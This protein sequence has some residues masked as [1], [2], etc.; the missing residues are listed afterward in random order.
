MHDAPHP[1]RLLII[2]NDR[3]GDLLL[4]LPAL[5]YARQVWP[6][7]QIS[8]LVSTRTASL[9]RGN[10]HVDQVLLDDGKASA[11]ALAAQLR[12]HA[13][14]AAIAVF[15][16]T[17]NCLAIWQARI[18]LRVTWAHK[19]VGCLLGNRRV[20]VR[21]SHPPVHES[22]FALAFVRRLKNV[23]GVTL[24]PPSI[25]VDPDARRR[26][27]LRIQND[28]GDQGP[29]FGIHPGSY[30]S[31]YNWPASRYVELASRL[32]AHGRV[33]VTGGPGEREMLA[34]M[35]SQLPAAI[36][37]RVA[38]YHEFDLQE[39]AAAISRYDVLTVSNTGP[40]HLAG[41]VGTPLV[42]L[43][44]AHPAHSAAKWEPFGQRKTLLHAP[45]LP[46]ERP[47]IPPEASV[48][49]M[50]RISVDDVVRANLAHLPPASHRQSA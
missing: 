49:H 18:P 30:G 31:T 40:M 41:V 3:V 1:R 22:E 28:L 8:V 45:L 46:G 21:R 20:W 39:L 47:E 37:P 43:F 16:N 36:R 19:P 23:E 24:T 4:T 13:F 38:F 35:Q 25:S 12:Q 5:E 7:M 29:C 50:C 44:S 27:E 42:A 10:S 17:R 32:A 15:T 14:D 11:R 48:E 34:S 9:L 2:R 26:V 33:V 6:D